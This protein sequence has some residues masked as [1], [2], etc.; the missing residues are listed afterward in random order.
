MNPDDDDFIVDDIEEG[1]DLDESDIQSSDDDQRGSET[2][3]DEE[4]L[5]N[6]ST[7]EE[8]DVDIEA[9]FD[10][11]LDAEPDL[12]DASNYP[13]VSP[14]P[15]LPMGEYEDDLSILAGHRRY[16]DLN[17]EL[18]TVEPG[19]LFADLHPP[20]PTTTPS[21]TISTEL[22]KPRRPPKEKRAFSPSAPQR[23]P[24]YALFYVHFISDYFRSYHSAEA[25][26][27]RQCKAI[28]RR[29]FALK[30]RIFIVAYFR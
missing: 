20:E 4:E 24:L 30:V 5:T 6:G 27:L 1:S 21:T 26:G 22:P 16:D 23:T 12:V 29:F 7:S 25:R 17:S 15:L 28:I 2:S 3:G 11:E 13:G 9:D 19:Q 8:G 18:L 14:T 10:G